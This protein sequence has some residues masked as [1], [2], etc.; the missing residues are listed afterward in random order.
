MNI[1]L[2]KVTQKE[3]GQKAHKTVSARELYEVLGVKKDYTNWIKQQIEVLGLEENIDY[4]WFA[5]KGESKGRGGDRRSVDYIVNVNTA[6]HISM[7]SRTEKGKEVRQYFID[8]EEKYQEQLKNEMKFDLV[9]EM[10]SKFTGLENGLNE[11]KDNIFAMY[12][13]Q[14]KFIHVAELAKELLEICNVKQKDE[15]VNHL[16]NKLDKKLET[17]NQI[18]YQEILDDNYVDYLKELRKLRTE[19]D[20]KEKSHEK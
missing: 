10:D 8:V 15:M 12:E 7:A 14:F 16:L 19:L 20:K 13:M 9:C 6:K 4:V 3:I 17:L 1:K 18:H 5:L 2:I 11:Y